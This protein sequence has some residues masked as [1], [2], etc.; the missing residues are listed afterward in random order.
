MNVSEWGPEPDLRV[1]QDISF[2]LFILLGFTAV[3]EQNILRFEICV[4]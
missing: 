4:R 3:I 1:E 2:C